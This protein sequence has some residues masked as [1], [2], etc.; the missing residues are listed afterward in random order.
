VLLFD[1]EKQEMN[2][3]KQ[4]SLGFP[5]KQC[6]EKMECAQRRIWIKD[7]SLM[8]FGNFRDFASLLVAIKQ[9]APMVDVKI[10]LCDVEHNE[11]F[12]DLH[13]KE[14]KEHFSEIMGCSKFLQDH[15]CDIRLYTK[16]MH[17]SFICVDDFIF[18]I[19]F[20]EERRSSQCICQWG[21]IAD[22][23]TWSEEIECFPFLWTVSLRFARSLNTDASRRYIESL[24]NEGRGQIIDDDPNDP[25]SRFPCI[26]DVLNE[27]CFDDVHY[28]DVHT[29]DEDINDKGIEDVDIGDVDIDNLPNDDEEV[30]YEDFWND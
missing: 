6:V 2:P 5:Q 7:V 13:P 9:K 10:V 14:L 17:S 22:N 24:E 19:P 3:N 4:E 8:S 28:D 12:H 26:E 29:D 1:N 11:R 15:D 27:E 18:H 30:Y 20:F 16:V 23:S 21:N 25:N